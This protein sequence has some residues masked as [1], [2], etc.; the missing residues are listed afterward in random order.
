MKESLT[1]LA[2]ISFLIIVWR[3]I[4]IDGFVVA[5]DVRIYLIASTILYIGIPSLAILF[6]DLSTL[7][8]ESENAKNWYVN[9]SLSIIVIATSEYIV[10]SGFSRSHS[11]K[12]RWAQDRKITPHY[13][14]T[15]LIVL[16]VAASAYA[17]VVLT[18]N[19][20]NIISTIGDR[21][22]ASALKTS[23]NEQ[24]KLMLTMNIGCASIIAL[25]LLNKKFKYVILLAPYLAFDI[26]F[27]ARDYLF[28]AM[29]VI[30]VIRIFNGGE[31]KMKHGVYIFLILYAVEF[32]RASW[33]RE[34]L[35]AEGI[36]ALIQMPG[37]LIGTTMATFV[38]ADSMEKTELL[39][40]LAHNILFFWL[41]GSLRPEIFTDLL[42]VRDVLS[43]HSPFTWGL[44]GSLL[45]EVAILPNFMMWIYPTIFIVY[46]LLYGYIIS[47]VNRY[48][49]AIVLFFCITN[50]LA[51]QRGGILYASLIPLYYFI[52][53][54][55]AFILLNKII[56]NSRRQSAD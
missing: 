27:L 35:M 7:Y 41:P 8:G 42:S 44:G 25:S 55:I 10:R 56:K 30:F 49:G 18:A 48:N 21:S 53:F 26:L 36:S 39:S 13:I 54:Q 5:L 16:A 32:F 46:S 11:S 40:Y 6:F 29:V 28:I 17:A 24:Y 47:K 3:R 34:S 51:I 37:E 50:V 43:E 52:Y 38:V 12:I 9:I 14:K 15:S 4:R 33:N 31:I 22:L 19:L 45:S 20:P 2:I 23:L 1:I